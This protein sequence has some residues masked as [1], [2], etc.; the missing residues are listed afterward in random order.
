MPLSK[1]IVFA[2][3]LNHFP[4]ACKALGEGHIVSTLDC[5]RFSLWVCDF[6]QSLQQHTVL[7]GF[8][9]PVKFRNFFCPQGPSINAIILDFPFGQPS[10]NYLHTFL[11]LPSHG[12]N[13]RNRS[14]YCL[15]NIFLRPEQIF[16]GTRL[17]RNILMMSNITF[18]MPLLGAISGSC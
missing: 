2:H 18:T 17:S 11:P 6:D 3:R 8:I 14:L 9:V 16:Y 4:P 1:T 7:C 12:K 5:D 15:S 13:T 10:Y